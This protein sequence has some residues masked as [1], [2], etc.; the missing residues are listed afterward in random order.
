L[1]IGASPLNFLKKM[2]FIALRNKNFTLEHVIYQ[3]LQMKTFTDAC[4]FES[5]PGL[6]TKQIA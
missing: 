2:H 3:S 6:N 1:G 4:G 5:H